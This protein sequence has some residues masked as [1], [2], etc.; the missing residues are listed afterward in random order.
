[1]RVVAKMAT[2]LDARYQAQE[3]NGTGVVVGGDY[4]KSLETFFRSPTD[5]LSRLVPLASAEPI[6]P[7]VPKCACKFGGDQPKYVAAKKALK[8]I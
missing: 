3:E 2:P 4:Y 8:S 1:M 5:P 7:M 6:G